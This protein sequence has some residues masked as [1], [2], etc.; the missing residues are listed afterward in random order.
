M[1]FCFTADTLSLDPEVSKANAYGFTGC[2]SSVQYNQIA[3]LKA[4]LR[5]PSVAPVTVKG[6]LTESSCASI[7]GAD[8][9][10]ATTIYSSSGTS[11][12]EGIESL[13]DTVEWA[14]LPFCCNA[15]VTVWIVEL[16]SCLAS[17][18]KECWGWASGL[19][20]ASLKITV[21]KQ[22]FQTKFLDCLKHA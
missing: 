4:A 7:M 5:H 10:T 9:N 11:C 18:N 20:K 1:F 14:F 6:S 16:G 17:Q 12:Q 22:C 15:I 13:K 19:V 8:V 21:L 2:L 3:P